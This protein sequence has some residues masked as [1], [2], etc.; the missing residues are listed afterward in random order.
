M[1]LLGVWSRRRLEHAWEE[2]SGWV[3]R[4]H[5]NLR[6]S[7]LLPSSVGMVPLSWLLYKYLA[8]SRVRAGH[9]GWG[10]GMVRVSDQ[11]AN[12]TLMPKLRL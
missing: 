5:Y 1:L 8:F 3:G 7:T 12:V 6:S 2:V 9:S 10:R 4:E 11:G